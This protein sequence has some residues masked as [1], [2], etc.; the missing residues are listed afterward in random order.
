M[1]RKIKRINWW[2]RRRSHLPVV[3][4]GVGVVL[5]L[6]FNE[7]T[8]VTKTKLYDAQIDSLRRAIALSQDSTEYF[9]RARKDLFT[10]REELETVARE[11]YNMQREVEDIYLI[12]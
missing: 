9:I 6:V 8:S 3:I 11:T 12:R 1:G 4:L 2:I 7:E 5:L 10:N